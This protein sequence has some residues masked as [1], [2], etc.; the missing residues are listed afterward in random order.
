MRG[1]RQQRA[2]FGLVRSARAANAPPACARLWLRTGQPGAVRMLSS[3]HSM[4]CLMC[5]LNC[6][7]VKTI[8][9]F[10]ILILLS[11]IFRYYFNIP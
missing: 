5:L 9:Y 6:K 8:N 11:I 2:N 7:T 4:V 3:L 1:K 10:K